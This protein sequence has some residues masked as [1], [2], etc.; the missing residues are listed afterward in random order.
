MSARGPAPSS[1]PHLQCLQTSILV[2]TH[3]KETQ[4]DVN[5]IQFARL[6]SIIPS[7]RS[8]PA[9][10]YVKSAKKPDINIPPSTARTWLRKREIIGSPAYRRIRKVSIRFGRKYR[11]STSILDDLL[12]KDH[13]L[14]CKPYAMQVK[15]SIFLLS[16]ILYN[17]TLLLERELEDI[18]SLK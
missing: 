2:H 4:K 1:P 3:P 9:I 12:R 14:N 15:N 7:I 13:P 16:H 5:M 17:T 6:G 18:R 10:L 11:I 8:T